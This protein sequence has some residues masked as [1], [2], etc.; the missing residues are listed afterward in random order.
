[1][2]DGNAGMDCDGALEIK[3]TRKKVFDAVWQILGP[4]KA[5]YKRALSSSKLSQIPLSRSRMLL[6]AFPLEHRSSRGEHVLVRSISSL[7]TRRPF[8]DYPDPRKIF[9]RSSAYVCPMV[10]FVYIVVFFLG[11]ARRH[12]YTCICVHLR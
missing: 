5:P 4:T 2:I 6:Y 10:H 7:L 9:C 12:R 1:M 11:P 8:I 3:A